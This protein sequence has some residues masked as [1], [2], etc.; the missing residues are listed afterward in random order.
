MKKVT[1]S[2][3]L[4]SVL[5]MPGSALAASGDEI[6]ACRREVA[7][8]TGRYVSQMAKYVT[9]C[10]DKRIKGKVPAATDCN[11][12]AAAADALGKAF[13]A[14]VLDSDIDASGHDCNG[15]LPAE[16]SYHSCP[17]PCDSIAVADWTSVDSCMQCLTQTHLEGFASSTLGAPAGALDTVD[18]PCARALVRG[19]AMTLKTMLD[20]N[21]RCVD[22]FPEPN[23]CLGLSRS[24]R[25]RVNAA[26]SKSATRVT[27]ACPSAN[28]AN[29]G[30]CATA[31]SNAG[32]VVAEAQEAGMLLGFDAGR[33]A[34]E[35]VSDA[36]ATYLSVSTAARSACAIRSDGA[37]DCW[38]VEGLTPLSPFGRFSQIAVAD[39]GYSERRACGIRP[40]GSMDCW[41]I[42]GGFP[43]DI[44]HPAG[45]FVK[46]SGS[47]GF[48]CAIRTDGTLTCWG[49]YNGVAPTGIFQEL[50]SGSYHSCAIRDDGTVA[51]WAYSPGA[52]TSPP[53]GT[54]TKLAAGTSFTCGLRP[55]Q[56]IE[57]WG[58]DTDG[59]TVPPAGAFTEI[60][61][62]GYSACALKT[63]QTITCWGQS[64]AAPVGTFS[65][66]SV[67]PER[68][69]AVRTDGILVCWS[70]TRT[71]LRP[72][73]KQYM[74]VESGISSSCAIATDNTITC[75]GDHYLNLPPPGLFVQVV[76]GGGSNS[77]GIH[78][79]GTLEC[80]GGGAT[81]PPAGTFTQIS[82]S[83]EMD[84]A[85]AVRT[86]QS[87]D[88][89]GSGFSEMPTTLP[90]SFTQVSTGYQFLC[91]L[92]VDSSVE[93]WG[94]TF[95]GQSL[96][97]PV[98]FASISSAALHSCGLTPEGWVRCWGTSEGGSSDVPFETGPYVQV[99][100]GGNRYHSG[101]NCALRPEGTLDCWPYDRALPLPDVYSYVSVQE[102][103][104]CAIG[105][106]GS[107]KCWSA[108]R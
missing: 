67:N 30:T 35:P 49:G 46:V 4:A 91:G 45:T 34:G 42:P 54:F 5:G 59:T 96:P 2:L 69:C 55:D 64:P 50:S 87:A 41:A 10:H 3:A 12:V 70:Q 71:E 66:V 108:F 48:S 97:P 77:C 106:N 15:V 47:G 44:S 81:T 20:A 95:D 60:S 29:I 84:Y 100:T 89:W 107:W 63:D 65:S 16:A 99:A 43:P 90:G 101:Q 57:C 32:C 31:F 62:S 14:E 26:R 76:G 56:S 79:D 19:A 40:D 8:A 105:R 28:F 13:P 104:P 1:S 39:D 53:P 24:G 38:T 74:R 58:T 88:C 22:E 98:D 11:D 33:M 85:C 27:R 23:A 86:D 21:T 51:C 7:Q 18:T 9:T 83:S 36:P 25:L 52:A 6:D 72:D 80:W 94:S 17:V 103:D 61:A 68:S 73:P 37:A 102:Y 75:R 93:C 82:A 92:H 78:T